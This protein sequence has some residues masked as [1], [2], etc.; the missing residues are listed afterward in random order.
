[1][2]KIDVFAP[3]PNASV[4][5]TTAV[6]PGLFRMMRN[7]YRMS[8]SS[9]SIALFSR[10]NKFSDWSLRPDLGFDLYS[11]TNVSS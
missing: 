11:F 8:F 2:L 5:I 9:V 6:K 1:M 3:I 4:R 10:R 7:A